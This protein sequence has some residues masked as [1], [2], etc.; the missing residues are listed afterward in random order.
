MLGPAVHACGTG[1]CPDCL[2][3]DSSCCPLRGAVQ[4]EAKTGGEAATSSPH[5]HPPAPAEQLVTPGDVLPLN[6]EDE[7]LCIVG[8]QGL[9]V[10]SQ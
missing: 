9:K 3:V 5:Q 7:S 8:T 6:P 10:I 2:H 4:G 1:Q